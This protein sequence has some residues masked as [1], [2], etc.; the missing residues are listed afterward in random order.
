MPLATNAKGSFIEENGSTRGDK[1]VWVIESV[2]DTMTSSPTS[3]SQADS[4]DTVRMR[5]GV[6]VNK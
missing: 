3:D 6:Y 4:N 5:A 1:S 2:N